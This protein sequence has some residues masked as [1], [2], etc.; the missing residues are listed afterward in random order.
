MF[1]LAMLNCKQNMIDTYFPLLAFTTHKMAFIQWTLQCN[2]FRFTV[3]LSFFTKLYSQ[4]NSNSWPKT[5]AKQKERARKRDKEG[6]KREETLE[7]WS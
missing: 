6:E 5:R 4:I 1:T 7:N 2:S 3:S